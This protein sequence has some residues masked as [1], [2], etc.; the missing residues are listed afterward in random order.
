M[1]V[2][3]RLASHTSLG[4]RALAVDTKNFTF[5][6]DACTAAT[7]RV[8]K[9]V[10]GHAKRHKQRGSVTYLQAQVISGNC[11]LCALHCAALSDVHHRGGQ[12]V[13]SVGAGGL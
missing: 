2:W 3:V 13:A 6:T 9:A 5:S 7:H 4:S 12:L 8:C 1:R 11:V 10:G